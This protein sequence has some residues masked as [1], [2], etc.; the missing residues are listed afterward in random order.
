MKIRIA[1]L[2][3]NSGFCSRRE[4]EKLIELGKVKV[5]GEYLTTPAFLADYDDVI[6]VKGKKLDLKPNIDAQVILFNKP[7]GYT[8]TQKDERNRKTIYSLLPDKYQKFHYVGR[9]DL[10]S[11]GL[12]LLTNNTRIKRAL[13]LPENKIERVYK[14]KVYGQVEENFYTEINKGIAIFDKELGRKIHYN[15]KVKLIEEEDGDEKPSI[16]GAQAL[17]MRN[18]HLI[19]HDA[20][21]H[22]FRGKRTPFSQQKKEAEKQTTS[23]NTWILFTL[24]EGKNREIRNI[25]EYFGLQVSRLKRISFHK[26]KLRDLKSGGYEK[27]GKAQ[28]EDLKKFI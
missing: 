12:M 2:I 11:E 13:E 24:H 22:K 7:R 10:N 6:I 17:K 3:A 4:A 15:A 19:K 18:E 8:C 9:L 23:R 25:C 27:L 28:A 5:N 16:S 21:P 14:V 20:S 1:K 26:Y